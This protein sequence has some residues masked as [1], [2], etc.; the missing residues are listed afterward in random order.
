VKD[1]GDHP[2]TPRLVREHLD[3]IEGALKEGVFDDDKR[4]RADALKAYGESKP[5]PS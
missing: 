4:A 1:D 2:R 3:S 5:S